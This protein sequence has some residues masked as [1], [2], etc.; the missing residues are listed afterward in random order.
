MCRMHAQSLPRSSALELLAAIEVKA[1][2]YSG[3]W[4]RTPGNQ[5]S[6]FRSASH[7]PLPQNLTGP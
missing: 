5:S 2:L 1:S 7:T 3:P 6:R 4:N